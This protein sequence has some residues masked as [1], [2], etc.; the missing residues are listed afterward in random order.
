MSRQA[1]HDARTTT[2][3]KQTVDDRPLTVVFIV[4]F[5][6]SIVYR[7]PSKDCA[8]RLSN[9]PSTCRVDSEPQTASIRPRSDSTTPDLTGFTVT[10]LNRNP[11][12]DMRLR[13]QDS[14]ENLSGLFTKTPP[15][16]DTQTVIRRLGTPY[17]AVDTA[18]APP[19]PNYFSI[20]LLCSFFSIRYE[21]TIYFSR[22]SGNE[23]SAYL[24]EKSPFFHLATT[25][26][27][28]D[29]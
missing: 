5:I 2:P 26:F 12:A 6:S 9:N 3:A 17:R 18:P 15:P 10:R 4:V 27:K 20:S 21:S 1:R 28:V 22:S 7:P 23:I 19:R 14:R 8:S 13:T 25:A 11:C 16:A 29:T 24:S